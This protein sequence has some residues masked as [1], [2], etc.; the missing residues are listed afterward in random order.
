MRQEIMRF[1]DDCV[2]ESYGIKKIS[3]RAFVDL[4]G[5]LVIKI[6]HDNKQ[7]RAFI[8]FH[9]RTPKDL[10]SHFDRLSR[11]TI[12]AEFYLSEI[13]QKHRTLFESNQVRVLA[14]IIME[15]D[16]AL[17]ASEWIRL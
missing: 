2:E 5:F 13:I 9:S 15:P 1:N 3:Y 16:P 14:A 4:D 6:Y 11:S 8:R 7:T 17:M 10:L 12:R